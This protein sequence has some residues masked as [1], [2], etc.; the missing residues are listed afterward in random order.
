MIKIPKRYLKKD[1]VLFFI[2]IIFRNI[3]GVIIFPVTA[4]WKQY[5]KDQILVL[6]SFS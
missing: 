4:F 1:F 2:H 5:A 3:K 6:Q